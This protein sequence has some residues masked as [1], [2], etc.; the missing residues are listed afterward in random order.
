ML[1][2]LIAPLVSFGQ[3]DYHKQRLKKAD[4]SSF[5][6][7]PRESKTPVAPT[8]VQNSGSQV[9]LKL[10]DPVKTSV[11]LAKNIPAQNYKPIIIRQRDVR[12]SIYKLN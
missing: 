12:L 6:P 7:I 8:E 4:Y 1:C 3:S 11:D 5:K 10:N 2:V 9:K